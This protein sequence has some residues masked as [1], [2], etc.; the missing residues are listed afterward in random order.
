MN[1]RCCPECNFMVSETVVKSARYD[2]DCPNCK[3]ARIH[4][5]YQLGS[6]KHQEI[7]EGTVNQLLTPGMWIR[8]LPWGKN[9]K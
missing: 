6:R 1:A 5:F 9:N 3:K 4:A 7:C 2:Y 8:P